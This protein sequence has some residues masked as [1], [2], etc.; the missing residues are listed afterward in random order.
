[1]RADQGQDRAFG[2]AFPPRPCRSWAQIATHELGESA[3]SRRRGRRGR[4]RAPRGCGPGSS[5]SSERCDH[6]TAIIQFEIAAIIEDSATARPGA[7][8]GAAPS[9]LLGDRSAFRLGD[10]C[11]R[12][13]RSGCPRPH[14]APCGSTPSVAQEVVRA[15]CF[16][17]PDSHVVAMRRAPAAR[18]AARAAART[19]TWR[20][21]VTS[22]VEQA[23]L[24]S[25]ENSGLRR[26]CRSAPAPGPSAGRRRCGRRRRAARGSPR[27]RR[28]T[29]GPARACAR[30][31]GGRR[32]L[33]A[34]RCAGPR[35]VL[36]GDPRRRP[37]HGAGR[38][39]VATGMPRG[40][41]PLSAPRRR[42]RPRANS[43]FAAG[44]RKTRSSS[45]TSIAAWR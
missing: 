5:F 7:R 45:P 31:L 39:T 28:G 27:P 42:R 15:G 26:P 9:G 18:P 2:A 35:I 38:S 25:S 3:A 22:S 10:L 32:E 13:P 14:P 37:G 8:A 29:R 36:A 1:V 11:A 16:W 40:D 30:R 44:R 33:L 19:A 20:R 4:R 34:P 23:Q 24:L 41:W 43:P 17:A 6:G 12:T 21:S